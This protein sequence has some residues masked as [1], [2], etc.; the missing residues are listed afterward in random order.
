MGA[1]DPWAGPD[2]PAASQLRYLH[3]IVADA[4]ERFAVDAR[5]ML[6]WSAWIAVGATMELGVAWGLWALPVLGLWAAVICIG[7]LG[8]ALMW[9]RAALRAGGLQR[10]GTALGSVWTGTWITMT[11]VGFGGALSGVLTGAGLVAALMAVLGSAMW[12]S[13]ALLRERLLQA[14][15]VAWWLAAALCLVLPRPASLAVLAAAALLLLGLPALLLPRRW[16]AAARA[17][18]SQRP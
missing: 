17:D 16:A 11:L 9:R 2:D 3:R 13:A 12:A 7:W 5:P 15:A 6:W 1:R 4:Q 8:S 10:G 18:A 14:C